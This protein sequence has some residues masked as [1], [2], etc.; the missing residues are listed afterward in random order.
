MATQVWD[1]AN[2]EALRLAEAE[3][4]TYVPPFDHPLLWYVFTLQFFLN[5]P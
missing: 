3:G 1:D 2:A 4:L 5:A